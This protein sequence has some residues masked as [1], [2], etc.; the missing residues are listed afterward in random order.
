MPAADAAA[1]AGLTLASFGTPT[2]DRLRRLMPDGQH[3]G[4]PIDLGAAA[5]AESIAGAV[6][7]TRAHHLRTAGVALPDEAL[8]HSPLPVESYA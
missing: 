1:A 6:R 3:H 8:R 7:L 2:T 5:T 4:N